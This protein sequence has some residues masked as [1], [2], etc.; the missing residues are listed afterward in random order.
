MHKNRTSNEDMWKHIEVYFAYGGVQAISILVGLTTL[1]LGCIWTSSALHNKMLLSILRT[2]MN[3]FH[4]TPIARILNRFNKDVHKLD[5][6]LYST[7]DGHL[8]TTVGL[9]VLLTMVC[10]K[11]PIFLCILAPLLVL[12]LM[13]Q[14]FY[15]AF[16]RQVKRLNAITKSPVLNSFSIRAYSME[17]SL[18][19]RNMQLSTTVKTV[20]YKY[21]AYS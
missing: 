15:M 7:A 12:F 1:S 6:N 10:V 21:N 14:Q 3:F 18:T 17:G 9:P 5:L 11:I 4:S 19:A 20:F 16:S 13:I 2:P 8:E